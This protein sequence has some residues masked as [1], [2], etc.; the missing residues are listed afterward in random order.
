[1]TRPVAVTG[2]TG[3]VG[4]HVVAM[5]IAAG[6]PARVLVRD[7]ARLDAS[8]AG[9]VEIVTGDI[10]NGPVVARLVEGAAGVIHCAGA[11]FS[12][13]R[14][15]FFKVNVH[16]SRLLARAAKDAGAGRFVQ[17]SSL[18]ARAP[19]LSDYGASK[20][21]GEQAVAEILGEA[22]W[23]A[24]RPPAVYGPGDRA[25]LPLIANLTRRLA[26][27]PG[28]ADQKLSLIHV[29]DLARALIAVFD[30]QGPPGAIYELDD[31]HAGGY[32]W[33]EIARLA[34]AAQKKTVRIVHLPRFVMTAASG[35]GRA[36]LA[37]LVP[38]LGLL[39]PGKVRELYHRDW[40]SSPDLC[41]P[42]WTAQTG[43]GE[44]FAQTLAWYRKAGWL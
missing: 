21:G 5:L 17:V 2:A 7:A 26:F 32:S 29:D 15:D 31:G 8:L 39:S 4:R 28:R 44:G 18:V 19:H 35:L 34:G 40:V 1:M 33:H 25:T 20:R 36:G 9:K 11:L 12:A 38:Q 3:F 43:F 10:N 27:M 23:C 24:V 13:S 16:G 41:L 37:R 42:D 30:R 14:E 6:R 22:D